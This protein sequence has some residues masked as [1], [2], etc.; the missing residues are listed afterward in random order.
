MLELLLFG[1]LECDNL[2]EEYSESELEVSISLKT[3]P[4]SKTSIN[5]AFSL[6]ELEVGFGCV[7]VSFDEVG[8]VF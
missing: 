7:E 8:C 2:S 1:P 6:A 3:D 4:Q 5:P